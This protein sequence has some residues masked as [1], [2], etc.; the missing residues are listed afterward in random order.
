MFF[1][2][3]LS[4]ETLSLAERWFAIS[5]IVRDLAVGHFPDQADR[6]VTTGLPRA[7]IWREA[8]HGLYEAERA[9]IKAAHGD[10]ILFNSNFGTIVHARKG[11]FVERQQER[12]KKRY[13]GAA[14]YIRRREEEGAANLDAFLDMLPKLREWF[15]AHKLIVRPHPSEDRTFWQNKLGD[16]DGIEIHAE[17]LA[18]PWILASSVLVH[19]GCTTG[20]EAGLMDKPHVMFAP[21]PDHHHD[22]ELMR[23]FAPMVHDLDTLRPVIGDILA[24]SNRH[25]KPRQSLEKY[26]ASLIGPLASEKI[27][28]QFDR[29]EADA[30][31]GA[32]N[33]P[34]WLPL[35]Y[36]TP[37]HLVARY[38][39]RAAAAKA[40]AKQKWSG[41]SIDEVRSNLSVLSAGA[42]LKHDITADEI[43][44]QLFHLRRS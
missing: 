8:F 28:D 6:I 37:R 5:D 33:L 29:I 20:I 17:G 19:H 27:V 12:H 22:T 7:D 23:T 21:H 40:Y 15:P 14:D 25:Q 13:A 36:Y 43:F 9:R 16:V 24:G 4:A 1:L 39:P 3:R 32:G 11:G 30:E 2:T 42:G 35:L 44:P 34:P 38:R 18:T 10:F 41:T 31:L 26:F